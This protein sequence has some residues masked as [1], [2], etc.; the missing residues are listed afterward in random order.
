[1]HLSQRSQEGQV[2]E[3]RGSLSVGDAHLELALKGSRGEILREYMAYIE[4]LDPEHAGKLTAQEGESTA[5]IRRRLGAAAQLLGRIL[6]VIRDSQVVYFCESSCESTEEVWTHMEPI[7]SDWENCPSYGTSS[8]RA[9]TN[10]IRGTTGYKT[11]H[12]I[13]HQPSRNRRASTTRVS[14]WPEA[15][16]PAL[17]GPHNSRPW[18]SAMRRLI[19]HDNLLN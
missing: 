16:V 6:E 10:W 4:Q 2:V 17:R 1:M 12:T 7:R 15:P 14:N 8:D 13:S 5:A 18:E 3:I 9:E 11:N 19:Q